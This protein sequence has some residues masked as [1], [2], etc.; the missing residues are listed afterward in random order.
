MNY[1]I[2]SNTKYV[3]NQ[4]VGF[5]FVGGGGGGSRLCTVDP[6]LLLSDGAAGGV[7]RGFGWGESCWEDVEALL[8]ALC[9]STWVMIK[10]NF[11][12]RST[13]HVKMEL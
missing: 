5:G 10:Q 1:K 12:S 9:K 8:E 4:V 7:L 13:L 3:K 11:N 2:S 6:C